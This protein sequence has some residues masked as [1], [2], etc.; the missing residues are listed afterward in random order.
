MTRSTSYKNKLDDAIILNYEVYGE[1]V[2]IL[3]IHGFGCD[4][5]LMKEAAEPIFSKKTQ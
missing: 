1:G 3:L 5:S 4:L 2:P